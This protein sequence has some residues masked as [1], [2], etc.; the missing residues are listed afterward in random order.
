VKILVTRPQED[1]ERTAAEL[2]ARG[3]EAIIAPLLDIRFRDG[4]ETELGDVQAILATSA[5]GIRALA[6]RTKRR[7]APVFAVGPQTAEAARAAGFTD[8]KSADGDAEAL[9]EATMRWAGPQ[10]GALYHPAGAQTKGGLATRLTAAGF[11]VRSETLYDAVPVDQLPPAVVAALKTGGIRAV[12]LY[13]PR[14]ARCFARAVQ[15]AALG[16]ACRQ[17]EALCISKAAAEALAGLEFR[18]VRTAPHPDQEGLLGLL[19]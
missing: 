16:A 1:A 11:T 9:A 10:N 8:I 5:N 2:V 3:H 18:A 19:D 6:R 17:M 7:D 13:S 15:A 4:P 14:S 12:L